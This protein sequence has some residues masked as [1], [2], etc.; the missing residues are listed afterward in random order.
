MASSGACVGAGEKSSSLK[1]GFW[2][3]P[4]STFSTKKGEENLGPSC[5]ESFRAQE[6]QVYIYLKA[7]ASAGSSCTSSLSQSTWTYS[8]AKQAGEVGPRSQ[9]WSRDTLE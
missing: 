6:I 8:L 2:V 9:S 4:V 1:L 5:A 7:A 3:P